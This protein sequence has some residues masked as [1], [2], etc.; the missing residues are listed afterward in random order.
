MVK[1]SKLRALTAKAAGQTALKERFAFRIHAPYAYRDVGCN[2][3]F[4]A[5]FHRVASSYLS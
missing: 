1:V 2:S 5:F 4:W 3:G